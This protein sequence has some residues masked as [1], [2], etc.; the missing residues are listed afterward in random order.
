M[1]DRFTAA[2]KAYCQAKEKA[3]SLRQQ[4]EG[5]DFPHE[6]YCSRAMKRGPSG[7]PESEGVVVP[8]SEWCEPCRRSAGTLRELGHARRQIGG[9]ASAMFRAFRKT[10]AA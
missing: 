6:T 1:G 10:E 5:C 2:A 9:Y 4:I 7:D 3:E 8:E